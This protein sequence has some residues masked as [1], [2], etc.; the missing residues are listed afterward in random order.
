MSTKPREQPD[1]SPCMMTFSLPSLTFTALH[2]PPFALAGFLIDERD[3][4]AD[5]LRL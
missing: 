5:D 3:N 1:V 2:V 4:R